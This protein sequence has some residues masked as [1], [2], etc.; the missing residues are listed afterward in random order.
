MTIRRGPARRPDPRGGL[1]QRADLLK[2]AQIAAWDTDGG[3]LTTNGGAR[4]LMRDAG[5]RVVRWEPWLTPCD[6][7]GTAC[8]TTNDWLTGLG[9]ARACAVDQ[10]AVLLIALPPIWSGHYPGQP[11]PWSYEWQQWV[12]QHTVEFLGPAAPGRLLFELG[13]EPDT[14]AGMSGQDYYDILWAPNVPALKAWARAELGTEIFV[15]G[16]AWGNSYPEDLADIGAWLDACKTAYVGDGNNRDQLPDFVSTH[17]YLVTPGENSTQGAAQARIDAWRDFYLDL[18]DVIDTTFAGLGDRGFP[19][20]EQ[21]KMVDSEYNSTID[22]G[23]AV[24]D[25]PAFTDFYMIAMFE[26]FRAAGVWASVEFTIA[27]HGGGALDLL[28]ADGAPKPLWTS[29]WAR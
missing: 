9:T 28:T 18:R 7:R 26:M 19:V 4:A 5:L 6:L 13:N 8:Q 11:D 2:G 20:A 22:N 12:V 3:L 10:D 21:I 17:T 15:G 29:F 24:N 25:D 16:P 14:Y 1:W 27:S 23:S